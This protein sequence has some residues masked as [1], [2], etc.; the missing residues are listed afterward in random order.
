[1][2]ICA[3]AGARPSPRPPQRAR[4]QAPAVQ[5]EEVVVTAR[6]REER[7]AGHAGGP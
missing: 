6:R 7:L 4:V 1:M 2:L 5:I 3:A